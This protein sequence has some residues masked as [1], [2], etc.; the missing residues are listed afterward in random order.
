MS[1]K[2]QPG[3]AHTEGPT[4]DVLRLAAEVRQASERLIREVQELASLIVEARAVAADAIA[5]AKRAERRDA[6]LSHAPSYVEVQRGND[7]RRLC[8]ELPRLPPRH[9]MK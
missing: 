1:E 6:R 3:E 5:R 7:G 4:A 9:G 8:R 2:M